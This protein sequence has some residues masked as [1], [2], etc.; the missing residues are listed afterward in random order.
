MLSLPDGLSLP[1]KGEGWGEGLSSGR[2]IPPLWGQLRNRSNWGAKRRR[3]REGAFYSLHRILHHLVVVECQ[4]WEASERP[5]LCFGCIVTSFY[6][7]CGVDQCE[8]CY[9]D[10]A[11]SRVT[12]HLGICTNLSDRLYLK[13]RLL[14]QLPDGTFLGCLVH[15]HKSAGEC[16]AALIR[17]DATL[18][19]QHTRICFPRY[20]H[21][22]GSH[23]R[24][25]IFVMISQF[26][27]CDVCVLFCAVNRSMGC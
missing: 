13:A 7:R 21:T 19:E 15:L 5:P 25:W 24:P 1:I 8:V 4:G 20:D 2:P 3:E 26:L 11:S 16:P 17:L 14:P 6:F 10:G 22:V 23:C 12:V 18:H 9:A 27:H